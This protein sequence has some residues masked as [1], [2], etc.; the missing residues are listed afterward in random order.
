MTVEPWKEPKPS[1]DQVR[2]LV[3]RIRSYARSSKIM[4]MFSTILLLALMV[5]LGIL[6]YTNF[7]PIFLGGAIILLPDW[8]FYI[9]MITFALSM[10]IYGVAGTINSR[11]NRYLIEYRRIG[12]VV[13]LRCEE[14]NRTSERVWEKEDFIFKKEGNCACG[15][16]KY[17]SQMYI[18]PLP[19]KKEVSEL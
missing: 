16:T 10:V 2:K 4:S 17:I 6:M 13:Q 3:E 11:L 8:F 9:L 18:M 1:I 5:Q 15:G 7:L 19:I 14:C 12:V